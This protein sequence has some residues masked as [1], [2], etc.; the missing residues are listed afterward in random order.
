MHRKGPVLIGI[1]SYVVAAMIVAAAAFL[2]S[3][4]IRL[5]GAP[6]PDRLGL[7]AVLA[8]LLWPLLAVGLVQWA[9]VAALH[10]NLRREAAP[11][12]RIPADVRS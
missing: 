11:V 10:R 2:M 3:E 4:W 12:I 7:V 9:V 8:G 1:A 5:P 6:A